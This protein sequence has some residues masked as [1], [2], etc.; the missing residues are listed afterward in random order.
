M[1]GVPHPHNPRLALF[2]SAHQ[3]PSEVLAPHRQPRFVPTNLPPA[4]EL[5]IHVRELPAPHRPLKQHAPSLLHR[6][7]RPLINPRTSLC[8][9]HPTRPRLCFLVIRD[10]CEQSN[11]ERAMAE[12]GSTEPF[13][14][15]KTLAI[16]QKDVAQGRLTKFSPSASCQYQHMPQRLLLSLSPLF[17]SWCSPRR[18]FLGARW[19]SLVLPVDDACSDNSGSSIINISTVQA[20]GQ[21]LCQYAAMGV[22]CP[23]RFVSS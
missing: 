1:T 5:K 7:R 6:L 15:Q 22:V 16:Q 17:G 2:H 23:W 9:Q 3:H 11:L 13:A 18:C 14:K 12:I 20:V 4:V 19:P 21:V 10:G 8:R